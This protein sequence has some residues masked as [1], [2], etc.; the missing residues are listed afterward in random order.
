MA[1]IIR[2]KKTDLEEGIEPSAAIKNDVAVPAD[3]VIPSLINTLVSDQLEKLKSSTRDSEHPKKE[4]RRK[5]HKRHES[6]SGSESPKHRRSRSPG[7]F[8]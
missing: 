2:K 6:G 4:E 7:R 1:D 5:E 3:A 8:V